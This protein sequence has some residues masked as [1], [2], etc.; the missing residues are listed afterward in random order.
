MVDRRE[1]T[2]VH[3]QQAS[4]EGWGLFSTGTATDGHTPLEI[5]RDDEA[6]I[7]ESD[8]AAYAHVVAQA[9]TGSECHLR[10]LASL[11]ADENMADEDRA[12]TEARTMAEATRTAGGLT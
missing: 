5:Q 3:I 2:R 10:A 6:E 12:P 9:A 1:M 4:L 7:F 11:W 8:E